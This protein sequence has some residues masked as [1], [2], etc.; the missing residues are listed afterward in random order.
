MS[1]S[2]NANYRPVIPANHEF[3]AAGGYQDNAPDPGP[4]PGATMI[5]VTTLREHTST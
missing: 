2:L 1:S 5:L 3:S 4:V